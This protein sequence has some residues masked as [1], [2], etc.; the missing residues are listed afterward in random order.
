[1]KWVP[2]GLYKICLYVHCKY[3]KSQ[4]G[5]DQK[6]EIEMF[7]LPLKFQQKGINNYSSERALTSGQR[8][9]PKTVPAQTTNVMSFFFFI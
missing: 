5:E 6:E 8:R 9:G 4:I 7:H 3:I 1:M 2:N